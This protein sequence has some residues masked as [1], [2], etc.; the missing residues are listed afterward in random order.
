MLNDAQ[1]TADRLH[2][3]GLRLCRVPGNLIQAGGKSYAVLGEYMPYYGYW[4]FESAAIAVLHN[5]DDS[6]FRAHMYHPKDWLDWARENNSR[7][8]SAPVGKTGRIRAGK[9]ST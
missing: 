8:K 2:P 9:D 4:S 5:I 7:E 6:S 3:A 1:E